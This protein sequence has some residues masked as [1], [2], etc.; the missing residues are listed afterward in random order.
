MTMTPKHELRLSREQARVLEGVARGESVFFTGSAGTG[1]SALLRE[2]IKMLDGPSIEVAVTASTGIAAVNIGG[3]TLHSFAG[4][5]LGKGDAER[6]VEMVEKSKFA[7]NRWRTTKTLIVDE[8]SMIDGRFFDAMELIARSVRN[9]N[10][11]FGGIQLVLSGDFYQLPPVPDQLGGV[12]L[13]IKFAFEAVSWNKCVGSPIIL[14]KVFRQ[15]DK[16]FVSMLNRMRCGKIK[17]EDEECFLALSRPLTYDDGIEPTEL[18]PLRDEVE[19]ANAARLRNLPGPSQTYLAF[20]VPGRDHRGIQVTAQQADKLLERLVAVKRITLKIGAQVMLIKNLS[21]GLVNGL[22]GKVSAFKTVEQA[23]R[24]C[25]EVSVQDIS[26][27]SA[28]NNTRNIE[29]D[30]AD[31]GMTVQDRVWP[32]VRFTNGHEILCFPTTFDVVNARGDFEAH[33]EQV[34]LILAWAMSVHKSQGQTLDRVK[35]NLAR[36]FEKG[37][38]YVALSRARRMETLQVLH[39]SKSIVIAHPRVLEWNDRITEEMQQAEEAAIMREMD[40]EEAIRAFFEDS[41]IN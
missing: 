14:Q 31:M 40:S 21:P 7:L 10:R 22:L 19:C 5:G 32:L 13:P 4:V 23:L 25:N 26:Q 2:I 6:L 11:P 30:S 28:H 18:F 37:Q 34:P 17:T 29:P 15:E 12:M 27:A 33:R 8:I 41:D 38:A 35:V 3:T 39:F 16:E 24:D 1:K 20:D 9:D 36:T